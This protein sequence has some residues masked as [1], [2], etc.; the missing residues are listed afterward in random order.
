MLAEDPKTPSSSQTKRDNAKN[1]LNRVRNCET[2]D[3]FVSSDATNFFRAICLAYLLPL[4][5]AFYLAYLLALLLALVEAW[6]CPLRS[7][8]L[9][10]GILSGIY[11]GVLPGISSDS[12]PAL[13]L[14]HLLA[15]YLAYLLAVFLA[16]FLAVAV[17]RCPLRWEPVEVRRCTLRSGVSSWNLALPA[18]MKSWNWRGGGGEW[19]GGG[20]GRQ[21][22]L[23][24]LT[25]PTG[26]KMFQNL[27]SRPG[28]GFRPHPFF[29]RP[30]LA[31]VFAPLCSKPLSLRWLEERVKVPQA[32]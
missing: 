25:T 7:A 8:T 2:R 24:N 17:W 13:F 23:R 1:T 29:S 5:L 20:G 22:F 14:A 9:L 4:F 32:A 19:P 28:H 12:L 3:Y 26:P 30:K 6:R 15:F 21:E 27:A 18:A 10:S 11:C 31:V 16:F